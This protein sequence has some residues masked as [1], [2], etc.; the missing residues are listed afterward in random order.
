MTKGYKAEEE[1]APAEFPKS[2]AS[3]SQEEQRFANIF[4]HDVKNGNANMERCTSLSRRAIC[5]FRVD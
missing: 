3:L 5:I 2:F 4:T 1:E